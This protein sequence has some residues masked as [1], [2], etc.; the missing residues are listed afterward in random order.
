MPM[1][2]RQVVMR[3][4]RILVVFLNT[5]GTKCLLKC[6]LTMSSRGSVFSEALRQQR[7]SRRFYLILA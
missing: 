1:I 4:V 3:R 2:M 7:T 5:K 6:F